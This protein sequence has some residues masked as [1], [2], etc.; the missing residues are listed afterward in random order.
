MPPEFTAGRAKPPLTGHNWGCDTDCA[1][2]MPTEN[3]TE[4]TYCYHCR[5]HH[6][7]NEMRLM[8]TKTGKRW[9][10]IRSIQATQQGREAREAYGRLVT[11][12]NRAESR[13]RAQR[14]NSL[15]QEK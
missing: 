14:L 8:V 13:S 11:E 5:T 1:R 12:I 10:C 15:L 4:P 9:R 7:R 2:P 6:P 3:S